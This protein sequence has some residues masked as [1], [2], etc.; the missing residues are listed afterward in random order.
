VWERPD[1][2]EFIAFSIEAGDAYTR[3]AWTEQG[4]WATRFDFFYE[5]DTPLD[6]LR[7]AAAAVGFQ[8][9]ER[10][11]AARQAAGSRLATFEAHQAWLRELVAGIDRESGGPASPPDGPRIGDLL[12]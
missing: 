3:L 4:F 2:L 1:G 12:P 9:L 7:E 8:F 11:L 5:C 10:H 6:G